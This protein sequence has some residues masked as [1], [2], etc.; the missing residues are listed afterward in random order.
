MSFRL[1]QYVLN[2]RRI[3]FWV[4]LFFFAVSLISVIFADRLFESRALLLPPLEEG[5]GGLLVA[6][7]AQLNI[8]TTALPLTAGSTSAAILADILRSRRLG[9]YIARTLDLTE[10][11]GTDGMENTLRQLHER[12]GIGVTA[13]GM[14][15]LS[16]RDEDPAFA[17]RIANQ[18]ISGLDSLNRFLE[19]S[20]AE[21][22]KSFV[23]NQ[24]VRYRSDLTQLRGSISRF[25]EEHGIIHFEEQ[26]R[27]VIDVASNL[28]LKTTMAKIE[29]DLMREFARDDAMELRRKEAEYENLNR[30][31]EVLVEGDSSN[32]VFFPLRD[33]PALYQEYAAMERDLEV[34]ERVYSYLLQLYEQAGVDRARNTPTV[35]VVDEP[36]IP[37]RYAGLPAW[38]IPLI[39]A[40]VGFVWSCLMLAWW[41]WLVMKVRADDEEKAFRAVG[42]L[43]R[44]DLE[45]LRRWLRI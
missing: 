23:S 18:Y 8:P 20:R 3:V 43:V 35:Q 39:A 25:Q 24:L 17:A 9:E 41:G 45:A 19:F 12:T 4:T 27:G 42:E 11:Y 37:E 34:T 5:S 7:M 29:L 1:M 38:S 14:I 10:R 31:L 36:S 21:Q 16:V 32:A 2:R 6:W 13:T 33:M 30:Q 15:N 22:T 44:S 26:V 40:L 28:K